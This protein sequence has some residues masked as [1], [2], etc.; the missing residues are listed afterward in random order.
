MIG[1]N[2]YVTEM[3]RLPTSGKGRDLISY[4]IR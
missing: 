3:F 2:I 4:L 1:I